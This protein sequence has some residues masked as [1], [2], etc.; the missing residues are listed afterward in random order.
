MSFWI[1][2]VAFIETLIISITISILMPYVL[3]TALDALR[4]LRSQEVIY[5]RTL[6]DSLSVNDSLKHRL[7]QTS[8]I[9]PNALL[10]SLRSN[11]VSDNEIKFGHKIGRIKRGVNE[12]KTRLNEFV[13]N[14]GS[15]VGDSK[16]SSAI[17]FVQ[18]MNK[19]NAKCEALSER[20]E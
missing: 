2:Y 18:K 5:M 16:Q 9:S 17:K 13:K 6:T 15:I 3:W 20:F 4:I 10:T 11:E 12:L 8:Y 1:I 7:R 14:Y 19:L